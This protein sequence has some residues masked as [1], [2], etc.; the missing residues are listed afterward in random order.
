MTENIIIKSFKFLIPQIISIIAIFYGWLAMLIPSLS[1]YFLSISAICDGMD[2]FIARKLNVDSKFGMFMDSICDLF[3]FCLVPSIV[4]F[5]NSNIFLIIPAFCTSFI[6]FISGFIRL[7]RFTFV[8]PYTILQTKNNN[9]TKFFNGFPT[10]LAAILSVI[11]SVYFPTIISLPI[12]LILA[13]LMNSKVKVQK[14]DF[15]KLGTYDIT[16]TIVI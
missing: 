15:S 14:I 6:Y 2:G 5:R 16:K 8:E 7:I 13:Y 3:N 4:L 1:F 10:P 9:K 11:C 12:N